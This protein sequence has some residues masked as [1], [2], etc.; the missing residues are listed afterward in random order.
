[1]PDGLMIQRVYRRTNKLFVAQ[2]VFTIM[3]LSCNRRNIK[4]E[5]I[6]KCVCVYVCL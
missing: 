2:L 1:M 6:M 4:S 5:I 3:F